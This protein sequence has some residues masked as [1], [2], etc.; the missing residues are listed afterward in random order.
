MTANLRFIE[1]RTIKK[2]MNIKDDSFQLTY[3]SNNIKWGQD[4]LTFNQNMFDRESAY[5]FSLLYYSN[6]ANIVVLR[7]R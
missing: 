3:N 1:F 4:R 2:P 5:E 6:N 7:I